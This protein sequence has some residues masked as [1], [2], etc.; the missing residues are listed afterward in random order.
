MEEILCS[1][2][3]KKCYEKKIQMFGG[4]DFFVVLTGVD[5]GQSEES[6]RKI[7]NIVEKTEVVMK[8]VQTLVH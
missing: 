3:T 2:L 7:Q 6:L 8:Q 4:K 5:L 1:V